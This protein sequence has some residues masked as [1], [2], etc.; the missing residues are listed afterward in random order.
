MAEA[1]ENANLNDYQASPNGRDVSPI[2]TERTEPV[3][4]YN[5]NIADDINRPITKPKANASQVRSPNSQPGRLTSEAEDERGEPR[6]RE[7]F[8]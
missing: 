6:F 8:P 1:V 3:R 7:G 4:K 2:R 5:S